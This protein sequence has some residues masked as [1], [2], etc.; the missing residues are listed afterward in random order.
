MKIPYFCYIC[1]SFCPPGFGPPPPPRTQINADPDPDPDLQPWTGSQLPICSATK[2]PFFKISFLGIARPQPQF[3]HS[4]VCAVS[5][6]CSPRIGLHISVSR[7]GRPMV[8]IYKSLT[9]AWMW[10]LG[11]RPRYSFSGNICFRIGRPMVGIYK[12]LT[13]AWM[14]KLGLRPRYSFSGNICFEI[15]VFCLCSVWCNT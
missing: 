9:G 3:P 12:S 13:G 10:K 14:W 4:C 1:G 5:D 11:L 8:G 2:I 7:I 6:L 15:S